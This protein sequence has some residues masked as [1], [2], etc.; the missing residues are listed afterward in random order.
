[1]TRLRHLRVLHILG[2][3]CSYHDRILSAVAQSFRQLQDVHI[4]SAIDA[5]VA[6]I[7]HC[8]DMVAFH[9]TTS[10]THSAG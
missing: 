8:P 5:G 2:L 10:G 6:C 7:Q 9:V 4:Q 1:V 3:M